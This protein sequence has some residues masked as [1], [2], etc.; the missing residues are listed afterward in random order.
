MDE[1]GICTPY[2][3]CVCHIN[4]LYCRKTYKSGSGRFYSGEAMRLRT[5]YFTEKP[6]R[7]SGAFYGKTL[8]GAPAHTFLS[9]FCYLISSKD[10]DRALKGIR[11]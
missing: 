5:V 6:G 4:I 9:S 7:M 2:K 1:C 8:Q 11:F 3:Y 10:V